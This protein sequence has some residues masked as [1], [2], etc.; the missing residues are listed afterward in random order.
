M[1][2]AALT[3]AAKDVLDE[4][5][6]VS[7]H[8]FYAW[9]EDSRKNIRYHGFSYDIPKEEQIRSGL[10][11]RLGCKD[12]FMQVEWNCYRRHGKGHQ[13]REI[14]I[15]AFSDDT[16]EGLFEVKRCWDLPHWVNKHT[17]AMGALQ[18]DIDKISD[19]LEIVAEVQE[20]PPLAGVIA[21]A[22]VESGRAKLTNAITNAWPQATRLASAEQCFSYK[23]Y[24]GPVDVSA[25]AFFLPATS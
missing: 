16:L 3:G 6:A 24:E 14:D 12:V 11:R 5:R 4:V 20:K 22:F 8:T 1:E 10:Y 2:L 15:A 13:I 7:E 19:A 21:F 18:S 23:G 17:E 9:P 25:Y